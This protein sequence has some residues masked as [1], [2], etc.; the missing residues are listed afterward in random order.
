[1]PGVS[2]W[3]PQTGPCDIKSP[4]TSHLA[5]SVPNR[6]HNLVLGHQRI[7][8]D[9]RILRVLTLR[10]R[11]RR[12]SVPSKAVGPGRGVSFDGLV[13]KT[14]RSTVQTLIM[15]M[16]AWSSHKASRVGQ[17]GQIRAVNTRLFPFFLD[18]YRRAVTVVSNHYAL[19][20]A[21]SSG[22]VH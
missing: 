15:S 7:A 3:F 19:G 18:I 13:R 9:S 5:I 20:I 16:S 14:P 21:C 11:T 1:M 4:S 12:A 10:A 22:S 17:Y 6:E 8:S 2:T